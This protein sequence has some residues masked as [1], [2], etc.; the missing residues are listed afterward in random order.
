MKTRSVSPSTTPRSPARRDLSHLSLVL[1]AAGCAAAL[2]PALAAQPTVTTEY[3][4]YAVGEP[5]RVSFANTPGGSTDWVGIYRPEHVPGPTPSTKWQYAGA[6]RTNGTLT[7]S[8]F[9]AAQTGDW[10]VYFFINDVYIQIATNFFSVAGPYDPFLRPDR[11]SYYLNG[12]ITVSWTN[13]WGLDKDWIG[14]YTAANPPGQGNPVARLYVDGTATGNN[15]AG[16]TF[17]S[18]TFPAGVAQP[19]EYLAALHY[20][21]TTNVLTMEKFSVQAVPAHPRL[22]SVAPANGA[23]GQ[24]PDVTYTAV[25]SN[26]VARVNAASVVLRLNG[27]VVPHTF[28]TSNEMVWIGYTTPAIYASGSPHT[29]QLSFADDGTPPQSQ[30]NTTAFAVLTYRNLVLPAPI[31]FENFDATPEGDLPAGWTQVSYSVVNDP[32][33]DLQ[34]LNSVAY[35]RWLVVARDRFTNAFLSYDTHTETLDY[36]RVLTA[37]PANVVNGQVVRNLAQGRFAFGNSGYRS[38]GNQIVYLFSPA[39]NLSAHADVWV[40]FHSLYEQN[41]D[42]VGSVEYSTDGGATWRPIVYLLDGPDVLRDAG[43]RVDAAATFAA[44]YTDV[45]TYLDPVTFE[46][47]GGYYGA[48]IGV[49][50]N[51]W[52]TLAPFISPRVNDDPAE[53]KRV[54]AYRLRGADHQGSVRFRFAYAGTDSWYFGVDNFG[55]YSIPVNPL[56]AS[57]SVSGGQATINW[58]GGAGPFQVERATTLS[59]PDWAPVGNPV[60]VPPVVDPVGAGPAFYRVLGR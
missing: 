42:S 1:L 38:G 35:S 17:G 43:G 30:T 18:V 45:A 50:S 57:V 8:A 4:A 10:V 29:L 48:F 3:L 7:F 28:S 23:V 5:V 46:T 54:E 37:N 60:L 47:R 58:T 9:S 39:F 33:F 53:S 40:V 24:A 13:S 2:A 26:G 11:S 55:L 31:H 32:N 51:Q 6:G 20:M 25:I 22:L 36:Q 59:P 16:L 56:V 49:E 14:L 44:P 15:S 34:D 27:A 19:G 52:S 21:D 12:A 41:Q